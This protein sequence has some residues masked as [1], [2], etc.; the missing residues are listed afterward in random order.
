MNLKIKDIAVTISKLNKNCKILIDNKSKDKRNYYVNFDKI[1]KKLG[2]RAK[3]SIEKGAKELYKKIK[4]KQF[5][6]LNKIIYN[7]YN[8]EVK[9]LYN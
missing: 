6:N 3:Y 1:Y 2:F 5:R 9:N 4:E 8:I 7:N